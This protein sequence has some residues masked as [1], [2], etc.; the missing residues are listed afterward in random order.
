MKAFLKAARKTKPDAIPD[1]RKRDE[2]YLSVVQDAVAKQLAKYPTSIE[3]DARLLEGS[4]GR[5]RMAIEV[6]MGEKALLLAARDF[7]AGKLREAGGEGNSEQPSKR[8]R[9]H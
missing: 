1:K 2:I 9:R 4:R 8:A 3:E 6:R 5:L 7:V